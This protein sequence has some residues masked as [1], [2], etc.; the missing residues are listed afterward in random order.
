MKEMSAGLTTAEAQRRLAKYGYNEVSEAKPNKVLKLLQQFW[1]PVPWMLEATIVITLLIGHYVDTA[2]ISF[3]LI[4]NT[5]VSFIQQNQA[6]NALELLRRRL[7]VNARVLRN[8]QWIQLPG[9]ELVPGDVIHVRMG[10]IVPADMRPLAGILVLD[11]SPLTGKSVPV[12][13]AVGDVAYAGAVARRGEA[14]GEVTATGTATYFGK[15][16]ELVKTAKTASHLESVILDIVRSL[17]IIDIVLVVAMLLFALFVHVSW[18]DALPFA[19]IILVAA[20]PVALP[21]TFTLAQAP[22]L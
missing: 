5:L 21:A 18:L 19:L 20:V 1:A 10:D 8:G 17:V 15:T 12:E 9:R 22:I 3:L 11:Q 4:F 6:E 14:T 13:K 7:T 16:T 2:V